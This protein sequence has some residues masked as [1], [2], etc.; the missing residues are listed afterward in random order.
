MVL[1]H[2]RDWKHGALG[3]DYEDIQNPATHLTTKPQS[4]DAYTRLF[5][6][7]LPFLRRDDTFVF[8]AGKSAHLTAKSLEESR[9]PVRLR[10]LAMSPL[11]PQH[12]VEV[13]RKTNHKGKTLQQVLGL[14]DD[15]LPFAEILYHYTGGIP[16]LLLA[17]LESLLGTAPLPPTK[18][19][20]E[21]VFTF[22]R[23]GYFWL[24]CLGDEWQ[25][26]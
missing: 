18:D 6:I 11:L 5:G 10:L 17:V 19:E 12:I 21:K 7:L 16:R 13:L 9:S 23:S 22:K 25:G 15:L 1:L 4:V 8:C 20:I 3:K 26:A 14:P 24:L 2:R